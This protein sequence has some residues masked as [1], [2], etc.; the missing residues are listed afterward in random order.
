MMNGVINRAWGTIRQNIRISAKD[1]TGF[2]ELKSYKQRFDE[3]CLK[4]A[5]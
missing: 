4:L 3:E 5:D 2:C 1:S